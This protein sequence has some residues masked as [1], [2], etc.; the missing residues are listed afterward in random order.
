M[1]WAPLSNPQRPLYCAHLRL[2]VQLFGDS[3]LVF[4]EFLLVPFVK[5][6]SSYAPPGPPNRANLRT[7]LGPYSWYC[8]V[9]SEGSSL[10]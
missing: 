3:G 8:V 6:G 1:S 4:E 7:M 5:P 2:P 9:V 10:G